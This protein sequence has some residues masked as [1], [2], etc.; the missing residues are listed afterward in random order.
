M[1]SS[2]ADPYAAAFVVHAMGGDQ[3]QRFDVG[4]AFLAEDSGGER[5]GRVVLEDRA[6]PLHDNRAGVVRLV[7]EVDRAAAY[8]AAGGEDGF[9][10]VVAEHTF[11][12]ETGQQSRVDVHD[13]PGVVVWDRDQAEKTHEADDVGVGLTHYVPDRRGEVGRAGEVLS[14]DNVRGQSQ[15]GRPF[16]PADAWPGADHGD[17]PGVEFV[18]VDRFLNV[19]D[20]STAAG[21]QRRDS[22]RPGGGLVL[23]FAAHD[24]VR[25]L[26]MA[27][28]KSPKRPPC[29]N[30][31]RVT[32]LAPSPTGALHLGNARTFVIN[33]ALARRN[34]WRVILRIEDL[35]GPRVKPGADAEAVEDLR[36]LGLDWDEQAPHQRSDL[37]PYVAAFDLLK[38]KGLVYPCTCTRSEIVRAQSAPH[39]DEHELRYPGTCRDCDDDRGDSAAAWRVRVPDEAIDF[40]DEVCG[41]Q[42]VNVQQQVGDFVVVAKAGLPAY[43]LAVVV[44][45]ARQAVTD[46]LRGDDLLRS[47]GRQ[48][49]LY[50]MLDLTPLPRY[51][52]VPLVLGPDGRRLAKRHGDTRVAWYRRQGAP[53]ERVIGLM[54]HWCGLTAEPEPMRAT[55]FCDRFSLGHVPAGPVTFTPEHHAWLLAAG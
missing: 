34:D 40:E 18:G 4:V 51:W 43:Q 42:C 35:D 13:A 47:T 54:A 5:I 17:D 53:P 16:K 14:A 23:V 33:W 41:R 15:A 44:D 11:A 7:G 50:R 8:L 25:Y 32:R 55:E 36:W 38:D 26:T 39:G 2:V 37:S 1:P 48:M 10:N 27:D 31:R 21:D 45:D 9:V 12:A 6:C 49:W 30:N 52:H 22:Q 20:G 28:R 46:V 24:R 3:L 19:S 29:R